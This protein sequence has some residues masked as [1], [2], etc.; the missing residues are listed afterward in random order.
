MSAWLF[1]F[2]AAIS[3]IIWAIS[4]K[5]SQGFTKPGAT[6]VSLFSAA[7]SFTLLAQALKTLPVSLAYSIWVAIGVV[8]VATVGI[9]WFKEPVSTLKLVCILLIVTGSVG[10]KVLD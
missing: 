10:L 9:V 6:V 8:G 2:F 4:M 1:L 3:E 5:L 7:A